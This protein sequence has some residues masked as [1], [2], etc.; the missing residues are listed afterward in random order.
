MAA[1]EKGILILL[2]LFGV[3]AAL[4]YVTTPL[5]LVGQ[6]MAAVTTV[7]LLFL[8]TRS[9]RRPVTFVLAALAVVTSTRYMYWRLTSTMDFETTLEAA[10]GIGMYGAECFIWFILL[11]NFVQNLWPAER[12]V[13]P[14][15]ED[16]AAWPT[17]DVYITTYNEPLDVVRPTILAARSIDYP[18]GKLNVYVL[19]DGNRAEF[20]EFATAAG[21]GYIAR[22][23][24][25]FAKAGNL[26]HALEHTTG[27]LIAVFDCDHVP[28][29]AFLQKTVGWFLR[30]PRM[31]VVQTPHHF[32]NKDPV[33][34]NL[35]VG[36][37]IPNEGLLF[38]GLTQDGNDFWNAAYF[39][40]SCAVLRRVALED[41]GGFAVE[42][43]TEDAHTSLR[44]HRKGWNSAYIKLPLAAGLA[45]ESVPDHVGQRMRWARGMIQILRLE[46]PLFGRG[47]TLSQR[48]CYLNSMLHFLFPLP[49]I[50]L[51]TAPLA[52]LLFGQHII[53]AAAWELVA[54]AGPHL[55]VALVASVVVMDRYRYVLWAEIYETLLSFH[56]ALPT[57][58]T[59]LS[60]FKGRFN[61]TNKGIARRGEHY[62]WRVLRSLAL[63]AV[64]LL[65]GVA[66]GL[67]RLSS[68]DME[69]NDIG[70]AFINIVWA[71]IS[72]VFIG[73]ALAI[74]REAAE[75]RLS[76]RI[77]VALPVTVQSE[78]GHSFSGRTVD[79]SVGGAAVAVTRPPNLTTEQVMIEMPCG[80]GFASLEARVEQWDGDLLRVSWAAGDVEQAGDLVRSVLGRHNA[81][82]DWN[83][84]H[85]ASFFRSIHAIF[86]SLGSFIAYMGRSMISRRS[87]VS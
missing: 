51:L 1:L 80:S 32:Y 62:Q 17:V 34:R 11:S 49:R 73:V 10:L 87:T 65:I 44:L 52:Y 69:L 45:T 15:P 60:P 54:Y 2:I 26:N 3:A 85:P 35:P 33:E 67:F 56:L 84:P 20:S 55:V 70:T 41:I 5:T 36:S 31:A 83:R 63:V 13:A 28:T 46:N 16:E 47:L 53:N 78:S 86:R 21:V 30:D 77:A 72:L 71:L 58:A 39:C 23:D 64:L 76:P 48:L 38:Y 24:N 4:V 81:W 37:D 22:G 59:L 68:G 61:V 29:R 9:R 66:I 82:K 42:T 25:R 6:S 79:V 75:Y 57:V 8:V 43:V 40:G 27:E 18:A 12:P 14:L 7:L 74:G 19:D 50:V